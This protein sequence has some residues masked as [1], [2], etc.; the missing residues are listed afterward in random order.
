MFCKKIVVYA[1]VIAGIIGTGY[2]C[3]GRKKSITM[4]GST[5]FQPFA[6][7]LASVYLKIYPG[8]NIS[9]QGGGSAVGIQSAISGAAD[10]GMADL[11][12]LPPEA[13]NLWR[14]VVARDGIVMIVHPSNSVTNLTISQIRDIY[15]G[16]IRSWSEVGGLQRPITVISRESGSGTRTSFE[17]IVDGITLRND[18]IVQDSNG[19]IR[20]TVASSPDSI[21]YIS[22][23]LMNEQVKVIMVDGVECSIEMV[24]SGNYKLVRPVY[25]LSKS[26]PTG[27]VKKFIDWMCGDEGQRIIEENGLLRAK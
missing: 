1:I 17:Q 11:Y 6:E 10:I 5:A 23:G 8:V 19:S 24:K 18:A 7:K 13:E 27:E 16:K 9:V 2:G 25:L 4:A 21:G 12:K 14:T 20:T 15:N 3:G 22:H 26:E